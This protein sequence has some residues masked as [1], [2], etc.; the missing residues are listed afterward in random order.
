MRERG[1]GEL[2][3]DSERGKERETLRK[4]QRVSG[5]IRR[6]QR[7]AERQRRKTETRRERQ[8]ES[9]KQSE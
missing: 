6:V 8:R 4:M 9:V 7:D 3:R 1:R 5:E 2:G